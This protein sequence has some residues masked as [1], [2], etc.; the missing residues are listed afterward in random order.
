MESTMKK[1]EVK[2]EVF[3]TRINPLLIKKLKYLG[4]DESK[5]LNTL[6]EESIEMLLKSRGKK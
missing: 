5:P 4:V 3:S 1:P 6:L 2:R